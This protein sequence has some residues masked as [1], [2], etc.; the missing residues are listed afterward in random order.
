MKYTDEERHEIHRLAQEIITKFVIND[1]SGRLLYL[2]MHQLGGLSKLAGFK[3]EEE[4][5]FYVVGKEEYNKIK[6]KQIEE[7]LNEEDDNLNWLKDIKI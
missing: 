4:Y 7:F 1:R 3:G 5:R 2:L 6:S